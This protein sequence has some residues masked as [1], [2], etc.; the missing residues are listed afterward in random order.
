MGRDMKT[1]PTHQADDLQ[2][3]RDARASLPV[4]EPRVE[5]L[6]ARDFVS[7]PPWFSAAQA[8]KVL[9]QTG[10]SYALFGGER[11]A[12]ALE[13]EAGGAKSAASCALPL[14]PALAVDVSLSQAWAVMERNRLP[15]V[16]VVLGRVLVGIVTRE[17]LAQQLPDHRGLPLAA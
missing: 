15:R 13:L 7:L 14:G 11:L 5:E 1:Q 16:A 2:V 9:R 8:A 4:S 12:T 10:K 17:A 6:M 3:L